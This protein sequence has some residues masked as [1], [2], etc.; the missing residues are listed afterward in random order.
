MGSKLPIVT[1]FIQFTHQNKQFGLKWWFWPPKWSKIFLKLFSSYRQR[2]TIPLTL[3]TAILALIIVHLQ[4]H[5]SL[6][7]PIRTI[8]QCIFKKIQINVDF[9]KKYIFIFLN[10]LHIQNYKYQNV[11]IPVIFW[12]QFLS[13]LCNFKHATKKKIKLSFKW[14][15]CIMWSVWVLL[16][17]LVSLKYSFFKT[18]THKF[19]ISHQWWFLSIG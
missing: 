11:P 18:T 19:W 6:H 15:R 13:I 9:S 12:H 10:I 4:M 3:Q 8:F 7:L 1:L 16:I 17:W 14:T 2:K 5:P